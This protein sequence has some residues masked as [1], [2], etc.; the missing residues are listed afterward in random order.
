MQINKS[1]LKVQNLSKSYNSNSA[2]VFEGINFEIQKGEFICIIGHSG[3]GK[4][5][6][7]NVLAGLEKATSGY[8]FMM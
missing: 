7:L 3:C 8:A 4:T 6:I 1:F 5:T 2:P